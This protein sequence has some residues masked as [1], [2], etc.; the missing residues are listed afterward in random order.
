[1]RRYST[2]WGGGNR[3]P[4]LSRDAPVG[5]WQPRD[6]DCHFLLKFSLLDKLLLTRMMGRI[7][8]V[9]TWQLI[10]KSSFVDLNQ[11]VNFIY[12]RPTGTLERAAQP[13][14]GNTYSIVSDLVLHSGRKTWPHLL[15]PH[16]TLWMFISRVNWMTLWSRLNGDLQKGM[17][18]SWSPE[19]MNVTLF[20]KRVFADIIKLGK[21]LEI[22]SSWVIIIQVVPISNIFRRQ[23]EMPCPWRLRQSVVATNKQC[24]RP[25]GAWRGWVQP[26]HTRLQTSG[27]QHWEKTF[28]CF[29]HQFCYRVLWQQQKT[30]VL[31]YLPF[32][33]IPFLFSLLFLLRCFSRGEVSI[34]TYKPRISDHRLTNSQHVKWLI[35]G[36]PTNY[37]VKLGNIPSYERTN[38]PLLLNHSHYLIKLLFGGGNKY[39]LSLTVPHTL[40]FKGKLT[41]V[42]FRNKGSCKLVPMFL[43]RMIFNT[44]P[45]A[46]TPDPRGNAGNRPGPAGRRPPSFRM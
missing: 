25:P 7:F 19:T 46:S 41:F 2:W 39:W 34:D 33:I 37:P 24:W 40:E 22:R 23:E 17:S 11:R 8:Y 31:C 30:N 3:G 16:P 26:A 28:C 13:S 20:G 43:V 27:S 5:W 32:Y 14:P 12:N 10:I 6:S 44:L 45:H 29:S 42:Q 21:D 38:F 15:W 35:V 4:L 36:L 9:P 1:M 18:T